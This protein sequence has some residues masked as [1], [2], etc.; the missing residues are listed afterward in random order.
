MKQRQVRAGSEQHLFIDLHS[1][2]H[3]QGESVGKQ[4]DILHTAHLIDV[5]VSQQYKLCIRSEGV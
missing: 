2:V 3:K 5:L 1:I 4:S